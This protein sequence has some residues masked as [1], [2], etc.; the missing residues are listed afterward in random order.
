MTAVR[1]RPPLIGLP[2]AVSLALALPGGFQRAQAQEVDLP[3]LLELASSHT[4]APPPITDFAGPVLPRGDPRWPLEAYLAAEIE[5]R[6]GERAAAGKAFRDI[7]EW[8]ADPS[9]A[10]KGASGLATVALWRALEL[11]AFGS[12]PD[13]EVQ[14]ALEL[15]AVLLRRKNP[16]LER[17]MF[18][19]GVLPSLPQLEE[20]ILAQ[21]ARLAW[22]AGQ[23]DLA[24]DLA[25]KYSAVAGA[26]KLDTEV[27]PILDRTY[28]DGT[29]KRDRLALQRAE[30]LAAL[31]RFEEADAWLRQ[32][33]QGS[34]PEIL[35]SA[36]YLRV[37]LMQRRGDLP[38]TV[39]AALSRFID[40]QNPGP[41]LRQRALLWRARLYKKQSNSKAMRRDLHQVIDNFPGGDFFDDALIELARDFQMSNEPDSALEYF[42]R[43]R[44]LDTRTNRWTA[45][46][47]L[48]A[49]FTHYARWASEKKPADHRAAAALFTE[50]YQ[51]HRSGILHEVSAFWLGRLAE[52]SGDAEGA[53]S[54]FQ[55]LVDDNPHDY[56]GIRAR[57][58]L[59]DLA[60]GGAADRP[61]RERILPRPGT[62]ADLPADST[63]AATGSRPGGSSP[64]HQR[65]SAAIELYRQALRAETEFRQR[66]RSRR[67]E[68]VPLPDLDAGG[69]LPRMA[70][71][72]SLRLDV[73]GALQS[74]PQSRLALARFVEGEIGD[75]PVSV[76][77]LVV[78]PADVRREPGYL[79]LAYPVVF[80][81][82]LRESVPQQDPG[83]RPSLRQIVYA[84]I[85]QE[86]QFVPS[87]MSP[88]AALGLMQIRPDTFWR[89][90]GEHSILA[91]SSFD[92][93]V[94]L[95]LDPASNIAVGS[96]H[97]SQ[98][99]LSAYQGNLLHAVIAHNVGSETTAGWIQSWKNLSLDS[100][101]EFE[102]ETA[103]SQQTRNFA[104]RVLADVA[105]VDAM[106]RLAN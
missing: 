65:L 102:I 53:R 64:F 37:Q 84:V 23:Q 3:H 68:E 56:Y 55:E 85:R 71:L 24:Q 11:G 60:T 54:R 49:G 58:H 90:N 28:A 99:L 47:T 83:T 97:L 78:P 106:K 39:L 12:G 96:L 70:V 92:G 93:M 4:A 45:T 57:M 74:E 48:Q 82:E 35:S 44:S 36:A 15:T 76:S 46:A 101:V 38:E 62:L 69:W 72:L 100:D 77:L 7:V 91:N 26:A 20:A 31:N 43:V 27:Q 16:R 10:T 81:A 5:L 61:A 8:A 21:L 89:L 52:E 29:A 95:L 13:A 14:P 40:L 66:L 19:N 42:D 87:A 73:I 67:L 9:H 80:E 103:R 104:R 98:D 32:A 86:S 30:R 88:Q 105:I 17:L 51:A 41:R 75:V 1:W 34:D 94:E 18:Q 50:L 79:P 2:V 33:E 22:D 6:R 59:A 63:A 25:I